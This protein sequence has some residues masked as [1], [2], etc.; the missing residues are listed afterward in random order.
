M[1]NE[2]KPIDMPKWGMEMS[3]GEINA[4]HVEIGDQ[5]N[6]ED[7]L[8][9]VETSKIVNTVTAA[10]SGILRAIIAHPGESHNVGAL[11]GVLA[12]ADT[13]EADI[14]AFIN[15]RGSAAAAPERTP[16]ELTTVE[17]VAAEASVPV[18]QQA[19]V[20]NLAEGE[21]DSHVSASPVARHL[22]ADYGVNLNNITGTGRHGRVS[23]RDLE[24]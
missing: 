11:L 23:K 9:D 20:G 8:V 14:Q 6:A 22:A 5:V 17:A 21:D 13:S 24:A 12:S 19:S 15:S 16:V 1:T 10:H 7:D 18:Q 2:I 4:W 3:E